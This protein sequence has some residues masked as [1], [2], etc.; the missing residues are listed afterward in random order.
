MSHKHHDPHSLDRKQC[1]KWVLLKTKTQRE[2]E[3]EGYGHLSK[4]GYSWSFWRQDVNWQK[5]KQTQATTD[6]GFLCQWILSS[7][8]R[9]ISPS[10]RFHSDLWPLLTEEKPRGV[11]DVDSHR[12]R[13]QTTGR[14]KGGR[15]R[16]GVLRSEFVQI[17]YPIVH[18]YHIAHM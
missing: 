15:W 9:S 10:A 8:I 18:D 6:W 14:I 5:N 3:N 11:E 1:V 12:L 16:R 13:T 17:H 7:A 2:T 4:A